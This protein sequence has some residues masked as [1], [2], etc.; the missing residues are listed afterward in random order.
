MRFPILLSIFVFLALL[1]LFPLLFG[2]LMLGALA[3]LHLSACCASKPTGD[4]S[5]SGN[6]SS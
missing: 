5:R 4:Q 3:K 1:L 6:M 2:G